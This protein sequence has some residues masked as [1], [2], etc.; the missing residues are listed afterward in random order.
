MES[1]YHGSALLYRLLRRYPVEKL[2]V[3]ERLGRTSQH[4]HRLP[5]VLYEGIPASWTIG[6]RFIRTRLPMLYWPIWN[7]L[8]RLWAS[9]AGKQL[10]GFRPEAILT[11]HEGSLWLAAYFLARRLKVPLH[12]VVHDDCFRDIPQNAWLRRHLESRFGT[13]YRL[14]ASRF[15]VS[16]YMEELF[17]QRY[18]PRG[19]VLYPSRSAETE[20]IRRSPCSLRGGRPAF[21]RCVRR[22]R[23]RRRLSSSLEVNGRGSSF[24]RE[25]LALV[26]PLFTRGYHRA[27]SRFTQRDLWRNVNSSELIARFREEAD[28]LFVPMSFDP[29]LELNMTISFPSKLTD[30][31]AA[32]LPIII[33]GPSYSSAVKW[34]KA[35]RDCNELVDQYDR[36]LLEAT[37]VRLE[38]DVTYRYRLGANALRAGERFFAHG[39]AER[40]FFRE[41]RENRQPGCRVNHDDRSAI[42]FWSGRKE[43]QMGTV[44]ARLAGFGRAGFSGGF[45]FL[46]NVQPF[47]AETDPVRSE[48]LSSKVGYALTRFGRPRKSSELARISV[49]L[50]PAVR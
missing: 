37:I 46:L 27:R 49:S 12:L 16:P 24:T 28:A 13:I 20:R 32:G 38:S 45:L 3:F 18:G 39:V 30:Y 29:S 36:D 25:P 14:A 22:K 5:G 17:H 19:Y 50:Q 48:P 21:Y 7:I 33:F 6:G 4:E 31:T 40:T 47:L 2:R 42:T 43:K 26:W 15:C 35:N 8:G 1:S 41:Y 11:V 44:V 23:D 9:R 10:D 34:A